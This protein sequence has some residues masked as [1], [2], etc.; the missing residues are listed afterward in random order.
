[1]SNGDSQYLLIIQ[2]RFTVSITI[3]IDSTADTTPAVRESCRV[4]P[5]SVRFGET[6]YI[7]GV[8]INHKEFYEKLI[9][10]DLLPTTSQPTPDAFARA[11]QAEIDRGNQVVVLT[12]AS[13]L[14]GTDQSASIAAMDFP[15]QVFVVDTR[16][17][18]IGAGILAEMAVDMVHQGSSAQQIVEKLS[19]ERNY[20]RVV[21]MLDTLEYLKKGGRI[22]KTVAFAGNLL[23][24]KPVVNILD[25]SI[26]MLGKARGSKQANNLLVEEIQKAGGV[27]FDKPVLLGYTGLSDAL[28]QKYIA[29]SAALW[30]GSKSELNV[31]PI[32]SVIGTHAGP[33]AVA[34]AF[35]AKN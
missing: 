5:L 28:L 33:G 1:M 29:D 19:A 6:E 17:A 4:V 8:T 25:G 31:T 24:I 27:D 9:E 16:S 23:A 18:A 21:A 11:Y 13:D 34:V 35:F 10:S 30:S 15:G 22:S 14:S 32:G 2:R 12:L 3:M 26:H 20:V 7:D